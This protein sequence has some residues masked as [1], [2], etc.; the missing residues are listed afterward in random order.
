M[1]QERTRKVTLGWRLITFGLVVMAGTIWVVVRLFQAGPAPD[2]TE[3]VALALPEEA[4]SPDIET[5]VFLPPAPEPP[6]KVW[7]EGNFSGR[8][9][10]YQLQD[11]GME[12]TLI[13][14]AISA[15][16]PHYDFRKS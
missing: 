8:P 14:K 10:Y 9:F 7:R 11:L 12:P 15:F 3:V 1:V 4:A 5:T 13:H 2:Q 16:T 6:Q